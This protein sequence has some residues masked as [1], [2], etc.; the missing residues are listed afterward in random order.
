[1][2]SKSDQRLGD[3]MFDCFKSTPFIVM[4]CVF[5]GVAGCAICVETLAIPGL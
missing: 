1:M 5:I 2:G 4:P 3:C